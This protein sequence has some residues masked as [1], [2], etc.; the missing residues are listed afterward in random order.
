MVQYGRVIRELE[1]NVPRLLAR[2]MTDGR[3][4]DCGG[5][6]DGDGLVGPNSVSSASML[7]YAYLLRESSHYQSPELLER[8]LMVGEFGRRRRRSSGNYDLLSTNFDSSP[9]TGFITK[10]LA[11]AV[12]L[13]RLAEEDGAEQIS[14]SLGELILSGVP[15]MVS[16]GFHTPNHRWV[17]VAALSLASELFPDLEV[18]DTIEAYLA[19]TIDCN[20]D[21]EYIE[22]STGVYNAVVNRSLILASQALGRP[23][24]LDPVRRNLDFNYYMLHGDAT[25][26]TSIS[27]RQDRGARS[28]PTTLVDGYHAMAHIDDNGFYA[29]VADWLVDRGNSSLVCLPN[30]ALHPEWRTAEVTRESLPAS[31]AKS[32]PVSGLWRVRRDKTSA[33]AAAGLT[34]PFS[35]V[36]GQAEMT[37]KLCSTYFA[38][39]QFVGE[40]FVGSEGEAH[41]QHL[42]RNK[43]YPEKD[44]R[45]G[46]YWLPIDEV[47]DAENWQEVRG[48]RATYE[49][50]PLQVSLRMESVEGGFDLHLATSGGLD[51]VPFQI[52]CSFTPGGTLETES[53]LI[54]GKEG[55]TAF[56]KRGTALYRMGDDAISVGPGS[57]AHSMWAMRNSES[58]SDVFRLLITDMAPL[59]RTIQV[60][61]GT[62]STT[63]KRLLP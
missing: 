39:G 62:W 1:A 33:T 57:H 13:A 9:D 56:L 40:D 29:A 31:Y 14:E 60:R 44:Y 15:G 61:C 54:E 26:V 16:G 45:G 6:M 48:R 3:S 58:S 51:G 8:I 21:G 12:K 63:E 18:Q 46:I 34:S 35:I 25:V 11:P 22:R 49:L 59:E 53:V 52:E 27:R 37:L 32:F 38:T 24:L 28:V 41:L 23:E 4:A 42:G 5:F 17:L 7:A 47:V 19:E 20:A 43:I 50:P 55:N 30:F 10:S 2:Q 36:Y